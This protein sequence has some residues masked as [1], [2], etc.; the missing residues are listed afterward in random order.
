MGVATT[1]RKHVG[2]KRPP[3]AH[4]SLP[5]EMSTLS[6]SQIILEDDTH[7]QGNDQS[8]SVQ[9]GDAA[10]NL[11]SAIP[12]STDGDRLM[13]NSGSVPDL[14][15]LEEILCSMDDD[16]LMDTLGP[17]SDHASLEEITNSM[18]DDELKEYIRS[19]SNLAPLGEIP[20]STDAGGLME[21]LGSD[22]DLEELEAEIAA[23]NAVVNDFL[24]AHRGS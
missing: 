23:F 14:A 6:Q 13:D 22:S 20:D 9:Q 7:E 1:A 17:N 5:Q 21:I 11:N 12:I 3:H 18:D 19:D 8:V 4:A 10:P 15:S 24:R 16:E 2:K